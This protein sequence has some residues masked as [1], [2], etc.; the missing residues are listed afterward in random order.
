MQ[1]EVAQLASLAKMLAP[2][3]RVGFVCDQWGDTGKGKFVELAI[4]LYLEYLK[5]GRVYCFRGTGGP[6]AGHTVVVGGRRVIL[7]EIPSGV[8][9]NE[10]GCRSVIGP[11]VVVDTRVT[12]QELLELAALGITDPDLAI[13]HEAPVILPQH[14]FLDRYDP[15]TQKIGTTGRGIGPAYVDWTARHP[16]FVND[17]LNP[18]VLVRKIRA[19]NDELLQILGPQFDRELAQKIL[20]NPYFGPV[21][22]YDPDTI[23]D[24]EKVI[25]MVLSWS[26]GLQ[27]YVRDVAGIVRSIRQCND[28][29]VAEGAQGLLLGIRHGTTGYQTSSDSSAMGL[30]L[31][32]GFQPTDFDRIFG[33]AKAPLMTRVGNGP[34]PS[35]MGGAESETYCEAGHTRDEEA[36]AHCALP[37]LIKGMAQGP[38]DHEPLSEFQLGVGLRMIADEYGA[39]T[40]RPR[41]PAWLDL[42][43][44]SYAVEVNGPDLILTKFDVMTGVH[45]IKLC[46]SYIYRGPDIEYAGVHYTAGMRLNRFIRFS[47][48]LRH[49]E[50]QYTEFPG[51]TED[52]S[53]CRRFN[54]LLVQVRDIISFIETET[55]GKVCI[56]SVGAE[57]DA[58]IVREAGDL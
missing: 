14:I 20:A 55:G 33:I 18:N 41:R 42:V 29:V 38:V 50:P 30:V 2:F 15:K 51:W 10:S 35:E 16:I 48:I 40:G 24:V 27:K 32:C 13:S 21:N 8:L 4:Y 3:R 5:R 46:T 23:L 25:A 22:F 9:H 19:K 52:I 49:C 54:D 53:T 7:H 34:M 6:N 11:G 36:S 39:T 17:L 1:Q 45:P 28:T 57:R 58:F 26:E 31:G 47:E 44:L 43:A 56:I 12:M 37:A